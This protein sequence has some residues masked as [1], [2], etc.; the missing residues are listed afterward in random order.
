[1]EA[2]IQNCSGPASLDVGTTLASEI[3]STRVLVIDAGTA[4]EVPEC[5][6]L[7]MVASRP[8]PCALAAQAPRQSDGTQAGWRYLDAES[9]LLLLCI[10]PGPGILTY[11]GRPMIRVPFNHGLRKVVVLECV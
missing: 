11:Q 9:G 6:D 1:L 7:G 2:K 5:G 10:W 8:V 4:T 3:C